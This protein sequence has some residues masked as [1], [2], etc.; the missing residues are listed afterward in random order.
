MEVVRTDGFAYSLTLGGNRR[1]HEGG[2]SGAVMDMVNGE[3]RT[4]AW[5]KVRKT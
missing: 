4:E 5:E 3:R 1:C 2:L